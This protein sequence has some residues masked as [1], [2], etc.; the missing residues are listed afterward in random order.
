MRKIVSFVLV[1]GFMLALVMGCAKEPPPAPKPAGLSEAD[2]L[3][4]ATEAY[5]YGYPLVTMEMTR[6]VMT[7]VATPE[8]THGADGPV[9]QDA[10]VPDSGIQGCHGPQRRYALHRRP[11]STSPRNPGSSAS[12]T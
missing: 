11:G 12:R 5:I 10:R 4:I 9:R 3:A 2:A 7:N 6:R 1:I 8:G